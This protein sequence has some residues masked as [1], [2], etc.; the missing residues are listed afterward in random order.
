MYIAR[1]KFGDL[2]LFE[3]KPNRTKNSWLG[4]EIEIERWDSDTCEKV[5]DTENEE[6]LIMDG[7]QYLF[8]ELTWENS[9]KEIILK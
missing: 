9:P 1:D 4:Q 5:S 7:G 8:K 3:K 2:Y 6:P